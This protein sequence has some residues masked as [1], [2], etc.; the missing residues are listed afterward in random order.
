MNA[1]C[2]MKAHTKIGAQFFFSPLRNF[3]AIEEA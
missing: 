2:A 3:S 1:A